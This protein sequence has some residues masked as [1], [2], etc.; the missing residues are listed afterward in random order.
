[1]VSAEQKEYTEV[2]VHRRVAENNDTMIDFQTGNLMERILHKD[3]FNKAYKKI[4]SN[5]GTGGVSGMGADERLGFLKDNRKHLIQR[6]KNGK[7][8]S[9]SG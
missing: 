5:K 6:I 3:N 7:Y 1:M 4:K 9:N 2:F 8:Q